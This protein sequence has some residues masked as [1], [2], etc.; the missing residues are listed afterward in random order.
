MNQPSSVQSA[1]GGCQAD[2]EAQELRRL[3]RS[4]KEFSRVSPPGS[5]SASIGCPHC[6]ERASGRTA[7]AES[8]SCRNEYSCS[9]FRRVVNGGCFEAGVRT[10]TD[11]KTRSLEGSPRYRTN[12]SSMR[13][14]ARTY[15]DRFTPYFRCVSICDVR[16]ACDNMA[17]AATT[18]A[19]EAH[20]VRG[21]LPGRLSAIVMEG[22]RRRPA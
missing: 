10:R 17:P 8:S 12:S 1:E 7:Q 19:N 20:M 21:V 18:C 6:S 5:S 11:G 2:G 22:H 3:H 9:M 16:S 15:C 4:Q 13:R 14:G